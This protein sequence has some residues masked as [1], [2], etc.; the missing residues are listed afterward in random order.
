M[1][2]ARTIKLITDFAPEVVIIDPICSLDTTGN[3][4]EVKAAMM[5]LSIF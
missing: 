5:R 2:L 1:H 4:L 3:T